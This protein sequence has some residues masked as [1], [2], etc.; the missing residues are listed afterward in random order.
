MIVVIDERGV[1]LAEPEDLTRFS[2]RVTVPLP[3]AG[4]ALLNAGAGALL[5]DSHVA[6]REAWLRSRAGGLS[7]TAEWRDGF[8]RMLAYAESKGWITDDGAVR[9]HIEGTAEGA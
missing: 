4:R 1:E 8:D 9:A 3:A 5:D 6:V 7:D 2:A